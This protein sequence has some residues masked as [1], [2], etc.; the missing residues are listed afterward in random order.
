MTEN[1][2]GWIRVGASP[3]S[4][5]PLREA[6]AAAGMTDVTAKGLLA[7]MRESDVPLPCVKVGHQRYTRQEWVAEWLESLRV[8]SG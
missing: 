4:V 2:N 5:G 8:P 1:T 7:L 3:M 6:V